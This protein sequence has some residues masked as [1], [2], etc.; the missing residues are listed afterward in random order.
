MNPLRKDTGNVRLLPNKNQNSHVSVQPYT[1]GKKAAPPAGS[2]FPQYKIFHTSPFFIFHSKNYFSFIPLPYCFL[3]NP[4]YPNRITL[5]SET[6][7]LF[8]HARVFLAAFLPADPFPVQT[9]IF[10]AIHVSPPVYPR[11]WQHFRLRRCL[12]LRRSAGCLWRL[13]GN[14][15]NRM[16]KP[17]RSFEKVFRYRTLLPVTEKVPRFRNRGLSVRFLQYQSLTSVHAHSP[18]SVPAPAPYP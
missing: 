8:L 14:E 15:Q 18:G 17:L 16:R 9:Q 10:P 1:C 6:F 11:L 5:T 3:F 12:L 2:L 7:F 13:P 4:G